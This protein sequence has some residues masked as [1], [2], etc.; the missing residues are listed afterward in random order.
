MVLYF[1]RRGVVKQV[2]Q[3]DFITFNLIAFFAN[4]LVYWTSPEVYPR[5]LLMLAP[6]L[7]SAFLYLHDDHAARRSVAFRVVEGAFSVFLLL[8]VAG[9][10]AP[11]FLERTQGVP[12]LYWKTG[13]L[14]AGSVLLTILFFKNR[15]KRL[16]VMVIALLLMRVGFNWLVLPDRNAEDWGNLCRQS[17]IEAGLQFRD[18]PMYLIGD[19]ELQMTNAFYLTNA[20]QKIVPRTAEP[21]DSNAVYI[22]HPEAQTDWPRE[23]VGEF[24]YRHGK[25]VLDLVVLGK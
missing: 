5:Y 9:S 3:D 10:V 11:V 19:T 20:R 22:I 7:F 24:K 8:I 2:L 21:T 1:L 18:R 16:L 12:G 25:G 15:D 17:T 14:S 23:K 4:I 6:L 13:L